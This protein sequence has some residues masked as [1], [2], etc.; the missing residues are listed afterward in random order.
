MRKFWQNYLRALS[1]RAFELICLLLLLIIGVLLT[2]DWDFDANL[3]AKSVA[4]PI[5]E[6]DSL[7]HFL[8][9]KSKTAKTNA[10]NS[11]SLFNFDPNIATLEDFIILGLRE[12]TAKTILKYREKGGRFRRAEDL[13]KIYSLPR[14]LY[15]KLKPYIRIEQTEKPKPKIVN[16]IELNSADSAQLMQIP[17]MRGFMARKILKYRA[18]LGGYD[19]IKQL[20]EVYNMDSGFYRRLVPYLRIAP[21]SWQKIAI[22]EADYK[23]LRHP[24]INAEMRKEIL[25]Y[26]RKVGDFENAQ[27][28]L[29][30]YTIDSA[31]LNKLIPY[32]QF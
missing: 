10:W 1:F 17:F 11:D 6:K 32:L 25:A 13:E 3:Q 26:R 18:L 2:L 9:Q 20:L 4:T 30:L 16:Q 27:D 28:L 8:A 7:L 21:N 14:E 31:K 19:E 24:Y 12:K 5:A 22:N 29:K 15:A 23:K